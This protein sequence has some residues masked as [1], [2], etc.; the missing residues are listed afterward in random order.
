MRTSSFPEVR[1]KRGQPR[2]PPEQ[3]HHSTILSLWLCASAVC[4]FQ[5]HADYSTCHALCHPPPLRMSAVLTQFLLQAGRVLLPIPDPI[6]R[7]WMRDHPQVGQHPASVHCQGAYHLPPGTPCPAQPE[8]RMDTACLSRRQEA[9]GASSTVYHDAAKAISHGTPS[10]VR[11]CRPDLSTASLFR[12]YAGEECLP[13]FAD[14]AT[15]RYNRQVFLL[16]PR[17]FA[18]RSTSAARV[19]VQGRAVFGLTADRSA[20]AGQR[21]PCRLGSGPPFTC[22]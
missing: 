15:P 2:S 13:V 6:P 9:G 17:R 16:P 4:W 22:P 18:S 12:C 19:E 20:H 5:A 10:M 8:K 3:C 11:A 14:Y 7:L 1:V 21:F